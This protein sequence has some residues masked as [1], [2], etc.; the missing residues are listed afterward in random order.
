MK[1]ITYNIDQAIFSQVPYYMRALVVVTDLQ[2]GPSTEVVVEKLKAAEKNIAD[3]FT[4]ETLLADPRL[5]TWQEHFRK[6][7]MNPRDFRPAHD[8]MSRRAVQG[9]SLPNINTAVDIGNA[10]SLKYLM[11]IGVH[12]LDA[13]KS[14]LSL[15]LATGS[16]T[17]TAFGSETVESPAAGE[18]IL[19]EGNDVFTRCWVWRQAQ[20]SIT[21]PE[22]KT[23]VVNIDALTDLPGQTAADVQKIA[24]ELAAEMQEYCGAKTQIIVLDKENSSAEFKV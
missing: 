16:E 8:A 6:F 13:V 20:M 24:E 2:N 12:P 3:T 14:E 9:K 1:K 17:F 22:S 4:Q 18:V 19:A 21:L 11:P 23:L 7:G 10:A 5:T 15:R